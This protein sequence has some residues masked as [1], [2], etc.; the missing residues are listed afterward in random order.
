[1]FAYAVRIFKTF[2]DIA[3]YPDVLL[4]E[5]TLEVPQVWLCGGPGA[6]KATEHG[7]STASVLLSETE[8]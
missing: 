1:M 3:G 8:A 4:N 6:V 5:S 2:H 7:R